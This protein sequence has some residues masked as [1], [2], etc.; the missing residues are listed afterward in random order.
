MD[1]ASAYL[2]DVL[3][4]VCLVW[5]CFG[6]WGQAPLWTWGHHNQPRICLCLCLYGHPTPLSPPS[7]L[8]PNDP[9]WRFF[10]CVCV[11]V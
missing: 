5:L 10:V 4:S 2:L 8:P 3:N 7:P 11:C 9:C 6:S 1:G